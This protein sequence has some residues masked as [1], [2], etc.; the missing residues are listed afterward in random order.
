[1][2]V[3]VALL[4][5]SRWASNDRSWATAETYA[6]IRD[7]SDGSTWHITGIQATIRNEAHLPYRQKAPAREVGRPSNQI[8]EVPLSLAPAIR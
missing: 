6:A 4:S 3:P 2:L 7:L 1:M 5:L 8:R